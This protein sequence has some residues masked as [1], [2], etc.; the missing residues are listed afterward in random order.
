MRNPKLVALLCM[1]LIVT[2]A[3]PAS[4]SILDNIKDA[5]QSA[6]ETIS[7][8]IQAVITSNNQRPIRVYVDGILV[9]FPDQQPYIDENNRTLV[10]VRFVSEALGAKVDWI[11]ARR[12]VDI[13]HESKEK[14]VVLWVGKRNYTVNGKTA[15]MDTQ[16]V[17]TDKAR[18]MVPLRFVSEA[19]GADVRWEVIAGN[20]V[21][22]TFTMGQSEDE[23]RAII[24]H[25][26]K[27]LEE[28][29]KPPVT[30]EFPRAKDRATT[31][32]KEL[33][34]GSLTAGHFAEALDA[35]DV[36]IIT[37]EQLPYQVNGTIV[38]DFWIDE[39]ASDIGADGKVVVKTKLLD[40]LGAIDLIFI[41]DRFHNR[42]VTSSVSNLGRETEVRRNLSI[43]T[44]KVEVSDIKYFGFWSRPTKE[45]LLV[46]NPDYKG[47]F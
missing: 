8:G 27:E 16:A 46:E 3:V 26:R 40:R 5:A 43:P 31:T 12:E 35:A 13:Q 6:K 32:G 42:G 21:V 41:S 25:V 47:G 24:E 10:P 38:Y 44:S 29:Q 23:I 28:E 18:V 33:G 36:L 34:L 17:L 15:M 2:I 1:L 4:A 19:L 39:K 9:H 37:K 30:S 45:L 7:S 11:G 22:F 20:G 14:H